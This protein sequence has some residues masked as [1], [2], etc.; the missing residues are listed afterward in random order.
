MAY[1][2]VASDLFLGSQE[3]NRLIK[4]LDDSG[5]RKLLLQNSLGFGLVNNSKDGEFDNFKVEQGTNPGYI[6]ILDGIAIDADGQ[7]I[8]HYSEEILLTND[9]QFY[10]ITVAHEHDEREQGLC[11]VDANGN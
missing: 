11:S 8:T 7:L 10:W 3:L 6:R 2:K 1:F 4:F 9:N 5:F